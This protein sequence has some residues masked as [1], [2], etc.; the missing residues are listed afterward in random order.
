MKFFINGKNAS[1]RPVEKADIRDFTIWLNDP[2]VTYH[3]FYGRFP[4]TKDQ[5]KELFADYDN[6]GDNMVF[7]IVDKASGSSIGF[8]G[9]FEI[10][11]AAKNGEL[12]VIIGD[13]NFWGHSYGMEVCAMLTH[14]GFDKLKLNVMYHGTSRPDNRG[15]I[16]LFELLGHK[17]GG[18]KRQVLYRNGRYYDGTMMDILRSDYYPR[19]LKS[20]QKNFKIEIISK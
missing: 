19:I 1:L 9:I 5:V 15:A 6:S 16:K 11:F 3:L 17:L 13:K 20:Y 2:I 4:T 7:T 14:L 8:A 18:V 12:R 10:D